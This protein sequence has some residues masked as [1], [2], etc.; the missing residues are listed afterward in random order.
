MSLY[1]G[2]PT[3]RAPFR[4]SYGA[5]VVRLALAFVAV[6]LL[7]T[8]VGA[9]TQSQQSV[10]VPELARDNMSLVAAS[11]AQIKTVLVQDTGLMVELK[12]WVAQDATN[13]GQIITESD[14]TEDSI[15]QRLE[16][17][18][19]FRAVATALLQRYGYLVPTVNPESEAA[20]EQDLL[21][22]ERVK[23]ITQEEE[24]A[25]QQQASE[26]Q[27]RLEK[28]RKCRQGDQTSCPGAQQQQQLQPQLPPY[29]FQG[30][31]QEIIPGLSPNFGNPN[32]LNPPAM[33]P[34]GGNDLLERAE[35]MQTGSSSDQLLG[36]S[37]AGGLGS[38]DSF[39]GL[40][41]V[42]GLGSSA[43]TA[44]GESSGSSL[45]QQLQNG[46]TGDTG[47][48]LSGGGGRLGSLQSSMMGQYLSGT[49]MV[50]SIDQTDVS[51]FDMNAAG[52][53]YGYG[54]TPYG[55]SNSPYNG[56]RQP[57]YRNYQNQATLQPVEMVRHASPYAD[58]PS[59]YDM[60]MQA[61]P[62]PAEPRRFGISVFENEAQNPD[63]IPMDLPAGPD[64][65]VGPGDGLAI[66]LWGSVSRRIYRTVDR[67]GRLSL[68][69]VG[70]VLVSG[71]SLADVQQSVQQVLRTQFRDVSADVSLS[72]LRTVRVYVVGDVANP[73]AYDISSLSTPLNALFAA[74]GPTSRGS[75]RIVRQIR[76]DQTVQ[77]V[78][79][80]DLLLHGVKSDMQRLEN[81][82]SVMVPPIGAQ[83]TVEGMVRRP[84]IYELKDEKSLSSVL[85]LA[86]GLLPVATLRH[87]EVQRTVAHQKQTMLSLDIPASDDDA[88][89][90]KKL[91]SFEIQDGDRIRIFPIAQ[92]TEDAVYLEGYV[93]RPGRYSYH[94]GM[95][96]TDLVSSFKD[97]L[98]EPSLEYAEIIRLNAP[99]FHPSV[100]SFDLQE[101]L[102]DPSKA[103]VLQAMDTVR[104]FSRFDFEN[105]PSVSVLGDV[106]GP[107]TYRTSG[108]I[109]VADAVHLAGGLAPDAEVEDAQVFRYLSDGQAKIFSVSLNAAL[110]GDPAANIMLEPRDRLLIHKSPNAEQPATVYIMGEVGKPGRYPLT[111]NMTVAD[112][113]KVGGG[114]KPSADTQVGDLTHYEWAGQTQL[115]GQHQP[116]Q[117]SEALA[118]DPASNQPLH[119]GDVVSIRQ[120]P[121]WGDLGATITVRGEV[122]H[123][124]TYGI[125]PGERLSSVLERA[126]GFLPDAY[127]Y[128]TVLQRVQ[129]REVEAKEQ[130]KLILRVK[131]AEGSLQNLPDTTPAQKQAKEMALG[132]YQTT[133][134][135]LST[136]APVGR[137]PVRISANIDRWKGTIADVNVRAGDTI[138][139]PKRP[140]YVMVTGQVFNPTAVSYRPGK[141]AKWYLEQAGGPTT[142]AN[143]K[144]IFVIRADGSVIG[145]KD[146]LWSGNSLGATLQPGDTVV[147]PEKAIGGGVQWA[148]LFTAASVA[149][150]IVSAVFIATHY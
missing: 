39:A 30:P 83:V 86:G 130:D 73:G 90:T 28:A 71:K 134:L 81:G 43:G 100:E 122:K 141:S 63:L 32:E 113:I 150:S 3:K 7:S 129:V 24:Q 140:D 10:A 76:G 51:P 125:R 53:L 68:P 138:L 62:R 87:I 112:L 50:P 118:G 18:V 22:Q 9:Q 115:N 48:G 12:R 37:G 99:D 96:V 75:L 61:L 25:R 110:A 41:G 94:Q 103:P 126:G 133:L 57:F 49:E 91:D 44:G 27:D 40:S 121:N 97:L 107:G 69:E 147:V 120:L 146:S 111:A 5:T 136:N 148:N 105:P 108:Q 135:E 80:Y 47:L 116:I 60:Y 33:P 143:R 67:E 128:G 98:P 46:D 66:D 101:A 149:S 34:S 2:W 15:F 70:P 20:K 6:V 58:I 4:R 82:D 35:L 45:L 14:L 19:H 137:V 119:N 144:A 109:H 102:A 74:G 132:Q 131:D 36:L 8:A 54:A 139:I 59:L 23:W 142:T 117:I 13:Q 26:A 78:D 92:G 114:L 123:P 29:Q 104:I 77:T 11:A 64:Y 84:A 145:Q 38:T 65:V 16:N 85:E 21:V 95:R 52:R 55:Y 79:L 127:P 124:G 72:R 88:A 106:R 93:I 42:D 89:A 17:D 56:Y 1:F 31:G